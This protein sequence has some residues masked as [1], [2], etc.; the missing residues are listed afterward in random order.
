MKSFTG[1]NS[2]L[3]IVW[4]N[5]LVGKFVTLTVVVVLV[6]MGIGAYINYQSQREALISKL[7]TQTEMLGSFVTSIAP[8]A[9]LSYD[10]DALNNYMEEIN[11]GEDIVYAIIISQ[12]GDSLTSYL[13]KRNNYVASELNQMKTVDVRKIVNNIRTN[14]NIL[15]R[16]FPIFYQQNMLG[17]FQIG[18]NKSRIERAA[19]TK[20][21]NQIVVAV[22]FTL[23]LGIGI[24]IVF[25]TYTMRPIIQLGQAAKRI[26]EGSL[27]KE[28]EVRSNDELGQLGRVFNQMM[29]KLET[30]INEK[31]EAMRTVQELN[32]YLEERVARR[33]QELETVNEKLEQLALHDSLT[34][35]PN[36]FSIQD[37][38]NT[39]L[40]EAKR[41]SSCFA[42]I[43]MDLD[44]FK[45]IND[46][47]GHDCGDQLLVEV[48]LRLRDILRPSDFIGRLGGDEFAIILPDT[49]EIGAKLVA[50]KIQKVLE[51]FFYVAEMGFTIAASFGI[52]T[53][54]KHGTTVSTILKSADVAMYNAK[55]RKLGFCVYNPGADS[56]TPDRLSLMGELRQAIYE[57]QL[58]LYYQPKVDLKDSKIIGAEALLRW[59]HAERGFIPPDEFI[60]MAE[61]SGLIRPLTYWVIKSAIIQLE[62]W[63]EAGMNLAVSINL[64]MHNLHDADFIAE[65][66]QLLEKTEVPNSSFEFEIT[67]STIMSDPEYVVKVLDKLGSLDVSLA[68]DDFGTGYSSLSLLKKL[69]VHTLKVDKSFV[70][71]MSTDSDDKAI[72]QSIIDMAHTLGLDVIAEGVENGTVTKLLSELGCDQIQGYYISRPL[73]AAQV[74]PILASTTWIEKPDPGNNNVHKLR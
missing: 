22:I 60:P 24:F 30:S 42:V 61:Q 73:P 29:K 28:V 6:L 37:H 34:N 54:P 55:N 16:D 65:L 33:T 38:L 71:E 25:R 40:A 66:E 53:F 23:I 50:K 32:H 5:S 57:N 68:I 36:R 52:A 62:E 43:M 41:D 69:P 9:M 39:T 12:E 2:I 48:G 44:R 63:Y 49:D 67:E 7:E 20:L 21:I 14:K 3:D 4:R 31:D 26:S 72:V 11:K 8:E 1:D 13:E 47:L 51:P 15:H 10:F 59:N 70:M 18:V 35:L 27:D 45:E 64:S 46:T 58:E 19:Q 74:S 17:H 56:N